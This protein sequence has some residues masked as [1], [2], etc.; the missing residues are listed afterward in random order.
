MYP[1]IVSYPALFVCYSY[2]LLRRRYGNANCF[3]WAETTYTKIWISMW[4]VPTYYILYFLQNTGWIKC[5]KS[6]I[7]TD[8]YIIRLTIWNELPDCS[9]WL[10]TVLQRN[11]HSMKVHAV[12]ATNCRKMTSKWPHP[13]RDREKEGNNVLKAAARHTVQSDFDGIAQYN[14]ASEYF[15]ISDRVCH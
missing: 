1:P 13:A 4:N 3:I 9:V 11:Q 6:Y 2:C 14:T 15:Q 10:H 12:G 5:T 8:S 7:V